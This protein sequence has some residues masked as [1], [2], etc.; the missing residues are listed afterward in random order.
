MTR[1]FASVG[2]KGIAVT[3]YGIIK[4]TANG[5][6]IY[7]HEVDRSHVL[8]APFVAAQMTD[9]LQTAVNTGTGKAAQIGRPVAGKTGTTTSNK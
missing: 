2:N 4:V 8:V 3:P 5:E 7:S 9:L 6:T 1:A